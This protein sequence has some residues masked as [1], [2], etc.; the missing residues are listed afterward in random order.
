MPYYRVDF[1]SNPIENGVTLRDSLYYADII[2]GVLSTPNYAGQIVAMNSFSVTVDSVAAIG[3]GIGG[4]SYA[5]YIFFAKPKQINESSVKG[6]YADLT[7][8]ESVTIKLHLI[9][10]NENKR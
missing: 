3:D 5:P 4:L 10:L 6:Y 8:A 9:K 1:S 7:K 2:N